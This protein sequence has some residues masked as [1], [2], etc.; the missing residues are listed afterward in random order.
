M[1]ADFQKLCDTFVNDKNALSKSFSFSRDIMSMTSALLL[2][3]GKTSA[4]PEMLKECE[5]IFKEETGVMSDFRSNVKIPVICK[6]LL[7]GDPRGYIQRVNKIY[8]MLK[9]KKWSGNEYKILA[10]LVIYDH[11][12]ESEYQKYV[13]IASDIFV[14]MK[15]QHRFLTSDEDIPFSAILATS[16]ISPDKLVVDM[17][18]CYELLHKKF[19]DNNA[20]QSLS[21]VLSLSD[22]TPEEK[23]ERIGIIYE[24]L[25][26][27]GHRFGTGYE[28]A[29]L[30]TLAQLDNPV[31]EIVTLIADA[32]DYLKHIRGFGNFTLGAK[33]RRQYAAQLAT[34]FLCPKKT[35]TN[36]FMLGNTLALT[37]SM[38]VSMTICI[39]ACV[40]AASSH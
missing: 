17:E 27:A 8:K 30:G 32:D 35:K 13:D 36:D 40:I 12:A 39:S 28:L 9:E 24:A 25:K 26:E 33:T 37:I 4:N 2:V 29:T 1:N 18:A 38:E 7:S 19:H 20:V 31:N 23:C 6:M 11:A 14:R 22:L 3:D 34:V 5:K 16:G 21:Q 15:E 10:A